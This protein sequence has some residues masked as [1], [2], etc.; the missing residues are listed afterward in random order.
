[1]TTEEKIDQIHEAVMQ[2]QADA[3]ANKTI[4]S[5]KH[6]ALDE[7]ISGLHRVIKGNGTPGLEEKL[8]SL[9]KEFT[10]FEAKVI[11]WSSV[12]IFIGT[13]L[14]PKISKLLP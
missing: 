10:K 11:A 4:C 9:C 2:L 14:A 12:A 1:M 13:L 5:A 8:A 7:R 3:N 6:M